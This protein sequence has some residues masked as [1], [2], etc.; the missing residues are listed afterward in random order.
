MKAHE[1]KGKH[2][3]IKGKHRK[4]EGSDSGQLVSHGVVVLACYR[5]LYWARRPPKI[6]IS[7]IKILELS[8]TFPGM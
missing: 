3:N 2:R 6:P 4:T 7:F 8:P 1:N 5:R